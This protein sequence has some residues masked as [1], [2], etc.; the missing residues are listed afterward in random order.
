MQKDYRLGTNVNYE[1]KEFISKTS[2]MSC[3]LPS[4]FYT[5]KIEITKLTLGTDLK[6]FIN[7]YKNSSK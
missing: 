1:I 5:L 3:I 4:T 7:A 6:R 2:N